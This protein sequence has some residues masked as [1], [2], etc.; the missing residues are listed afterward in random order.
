MIR[1]LFFRTLIVVVTLLSVQQL[2]GQGTQKW[3][4]GDSLFVQQ[5]GF[6]TPSLFKEMIKILIIN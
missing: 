4:V 6:N 2:S 5:T 3:K 1:T